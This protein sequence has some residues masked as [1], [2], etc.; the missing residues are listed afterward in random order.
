MKCHL[1]TQGGHSSC[2]CGR[3]R[4]PF[5][6]TLFLLS[7]ASSL[8][9]C[10]S[11]LPPGIKARSEANRA[12]YMLTTK[13]RTTSIRISEAMLTG[14]IITSS[15]WF[16]FTSQ[17][18]EHPATFPFIFL[19]VLQPVPGSEIVGSA[20]LRKRKHENKKGGNWG[21]TTNIMIFV[22]HN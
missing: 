10:L 3:A 16:S 11:T 17:A 2:F 20:E 19:Q 18:L 13:Y 6:A 14:S 5:T 9:C 22:G 21:E 8:G 1:P 15:T 4:L 7:T 12:K